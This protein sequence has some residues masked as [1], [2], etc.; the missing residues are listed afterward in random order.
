MITV[1]TIAKD[2]VAPTTGITVDVPS[3][4]DGDKLYLWVFIDENDGVVDEITGWTEIAE[5]SGTASD[6]RDRTWSL[7]Q[8]TASSEPSTYDVTG[9]GGSTRNMLAVIVNAG[10][11]GSLV[12][13]PTA[14]HLDAGSNAPSPPVPAITTAV[15]NTILVNFIGIT[16]N[17]SEITAWAAPTGYTLDAND[18]Q[19]TQTALAV[20]SKSLASASAESATTWNNTT[21]GGISE[22]TSVIIAVSA[23][24]TITGEPQASDATTSGAATKT[25]SAS[26]TPQASAAATSGAAT[27]GNS[28]T[29]S[30]VSSNSGSDLAELTATLAITVSDSTGV[31]SATINGEALSSVSI[32]NGTTVTAEVPMGVAA[33]IGASV[34]LVVNNGSDSNAYGLTVSVPDGFSSVDV[35]TAYGDLTEDSD[36][37]GWTAFS[38]I[39][40]GDVF[41]YENNGGDLTYS[42]DLIGT[43]TPALVDNLEVDCWFLD[44]S[45]SY[46]ADATVTT[47]T[48][49]SEKTL[50]GTPQASA[51]ST[52]GSGSKAVKS[53]G[54][55]QSQASTTSGSASS[56]D[57]ISGDLVVSDS[58]TSGTASKTISA[59]GAV[60]AT[61]ASTNGTNILAIKGMGKPMHSELASGIGAGLD[62]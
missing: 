50:S 20:A 8:R 57:G 49:I 17:A 23:G 7:Q 39:A 16:V 44:A 4:S 40:V 47:I 60:Q 62:I 42:G 55:L 25:V 28:L 51:A 41:I 38:G 61:A 12:V 15:D 5:V 27:V 13:T 58:S 2:S 34:D 22:Y 24:D 6:G 1:G 43:D 31:V 35:T 9:T 37:Y 26:G 18:V 3:N 10:S 48:R 53:S 46:N 56:I 14:S 36:F 52:S 29:I 19:N 11:S 33:D 32:L 59:S 30:A 54:T 21:T 45:D